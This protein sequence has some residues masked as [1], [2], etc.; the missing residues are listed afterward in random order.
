M[1]R[2]L[3]VLALLSGPALAVAKGSA[4]SAPVATPVYDK[5]LAERLGADERGMRP[6]VL[7]ILKTGPTRVPEGDKRKE[8]FAGHFANIGRLAKAGKLVLAG[9]FSED[10]D[11]WRGLFLL[12]VADIEEA[13]ALTSTDPVIV[14]GEMVAEFHR[15]YGSAAAMMLP[16]I[17][18]KLSPPGH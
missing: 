16:E 8:M 5:A 6:Y 9:P 15:W 13:R 17:H 14:N 7:V 3:A 12:A 4:D 2:F 10:K 18:D 11:G 1:L